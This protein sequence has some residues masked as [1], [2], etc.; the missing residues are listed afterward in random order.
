M[1]G[2]RLKAEPWSD[3]VGSRSG[4]KGVRSEWESFTRGGGEWCWR[5]EVRPQAKPWL[6]KCFT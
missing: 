3:A 5:G 2:A 6:N 4:R 1:G